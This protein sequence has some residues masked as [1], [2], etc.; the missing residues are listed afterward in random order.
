[1]YFG[2]ILLLGGISYLTKEHKGNHCTVSREIGHKHNYMYYII[3]ALIVL[4]F[5]PSR[6]HTVPFLAPLCGSLHL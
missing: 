3:L 4:D 2:L 6:V 1:M 5:V